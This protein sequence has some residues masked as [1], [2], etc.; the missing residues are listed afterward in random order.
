MIHHFDFNDFEEVNCRVVN[1][2]PEN[3]E[4]EFDTADTFLISKNNDHAF[5]NIFW[6]DFKYLVFDVISYSENI[7]P[8]MLRFWNTEQSFLEYEGAADVDV[9]MGVLPGV[10]TTLSFPLKALNLERQYLDRTPGKL[11]TTV[12]GKGGGKRIDLKN[13]Y[14]FSVGVNDFF[15]KRRLSI[16]RLYLS[17]EEPAYPLPDIKLVDEVGQVTSK[18]W[19]GKTGDPDELISFLRNEVQ[20]PIKKASQRLS[21][22]GG[23]TEK[24]FDASGFF[25]TEHDGNRW[26]LADPDGYAFFSTGIN[27]VRPGE[28]GRID[29]ITKLFT[30]LPEKQGIFEPAWKEGEIRDESEYVNFAVANLIRAYGKNWMKNWSKITRR[31]ML[32]WGFN[33]AG[34]WSYRK[35]VKEAKIPYVFML[36]NFPETKK[37]IFRDFPDVFSREYKQQSV[38][39]AEQL[40][41][42]AGDRFMIGYFMRNEPLWAFIKELNIARELLENGQDLE[43]KKV[44]L[45]FLSERYK[46][47]QEGFKEA[48]GREYQRKEEIALRPMKRGT[49]ISR[50]AW[51]D[52]N[53]FADIMVETYIKI[54]AEELRKADPNHL[55]LGMRYGMMNCGNIIPGAEYFDVFSFNCYSKDNVRYIEKA[56]AATGLPVIIGEY[57]H[58]ALDRGPLSSG[59]QTVRSQTE[60]GKAYRYYVEGAA[61]ASHCVGTHYFQLNDQPALGRFDGEALQTGFVD[62]CHKPYEDFIYGVKQTNSIIY[63]VAAG[64]RPP[65]GIKP[66]YI[67]G[68]G[69]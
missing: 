11:K 23:W 10:K 33:T 35:F 64:K 65:Y 46:N 18:N 17:P 66:D 45:S 37:K 9:K 36:D 61:A 14:A 44:F 2:C 8:V 52:L 58:C 6:E 43:S 63:E 55:N 15:K 19:P 39:F 20:V 16:S 53:D 12:F 54:P 48:W 59:L 38:V 57:H 62:V 21:M 47:D 28:A 51:K 13:F 24:R 67:K 31:R 56:A 30:R 32:E 50:K 1:R 7:T 60:R 34:N 68:N 26:W 40:K 3:I 29:Q 69:F 22:Y 49:Q 25:R 4:V 41:C 5:R 27:C 42:F